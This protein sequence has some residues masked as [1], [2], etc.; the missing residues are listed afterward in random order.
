MSE[1]SQAYRTQ[2]ARANSD[3]YS[4]HSRLLLIFTSGPPRL[5]PDGLYLAGARPNPR[6]G[7]G[8]SVT[9]PGG[10]SGGG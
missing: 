3:K 10:D 1:T 5:R 7:F 8:C 4:A 2:V 9:I 6:G